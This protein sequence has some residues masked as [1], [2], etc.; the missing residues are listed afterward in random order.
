MTISASDIVATPIRI[1]I[2]AFAADGALL[3]S[4]VHARACW[5]HAAG[6]SANTGF[7]RVDTEAAIRPS[8]LAALGPLAPSANPV[9]A[10]D[11][12]LYIG[13]LAGELRAFHADGLPYWT[14]QLNSEHGGIFA[15]PLI[16][17]DG[18]IYVVSTVHYTDSGE[19]ASFLHKFTPAG[20]WVYWQPFPKSKMYPATDGGATT[21]APNM[22]RSK[23]TEAII[24]PAVYKGLGREDLSLIAFSTSGTVLAHE[25]IAVKVYEITGGTDFGGFLPYCIAMNFWNGGL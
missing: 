14:R 2:A 8:Q 23:D 1:V 20:A 13:N 7:A 11:G 25:Q 6:D 3:I 19:N 18:S 15:A 17:A 10:S 22:W 16:G 12:T 21:A 4:A 5:V 24:V 9:V